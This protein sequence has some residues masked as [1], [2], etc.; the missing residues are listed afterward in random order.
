MP[1]PGS[2]TALLVDD[3]RLF[4]QVLAQRLRAEPG[5]AEVATACSLTEARERAEEVQP[6]LVLLDFQLAGESGIDLLEDLDRLDK[7][8][9][10][11]MLSAS[12]DSE[13]IVAAL[14]AG[15][16]GWVSKDEEFTAL[17]RAIRRVQSGQMH[18]PGRLARLVVRHLLDESR[19]QGREPSFVQ[20]ISPR[21]LAVLQCLVAGLTRTEVAQRLYVSPNTVRTHIHKL[22]R[23]AGLHST[24]SL[25][26]AARRSGVEA[27]DE[28]PHAVSSVAPRG[29][30]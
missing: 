24:L 8:P 1:V 30:S 14:E 4:A 23:T 18:L 3:H 9:A 16:Q 29:T 5:F 10:V 22:L 15:A 7:L 20:K 28:V 13:S 21:E 19:S 11:L 25:V 2:A 26:A 27:Y 12:D 6:D 17:V